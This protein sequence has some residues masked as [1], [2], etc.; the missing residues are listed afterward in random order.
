M[1]SV[2]YDA[3]KNIANR[4]KHGIDLMEAKYFNLNSAS[5][6]ADI[7]KHYGERRFLALGFI[8][9]RLHV[10]VFTPRDKKLRVISLRKANL[11]ERRKYAQKI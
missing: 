4:A 10:M 6:E 2:E 3:D 9:D 5:V 11:R 7:R 8:A 1:L